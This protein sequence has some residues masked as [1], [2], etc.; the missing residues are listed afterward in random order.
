MSLFKKPKKHIQRRVFGSNEDDETTDNNGMEISADEKMETQ[1]I[2]KVRKKERKD[3]D[4]ALPK[5]TLLSFGD[6]GICFDS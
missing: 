6:E 4:K 5:Q 1:P 3:K 2:T